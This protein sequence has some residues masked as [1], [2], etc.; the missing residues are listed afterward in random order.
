MSWERS[1]ST[2]GFKASKLSVV[3]SDHLRRSHAVLKRYHFETGWTCDSLSTLWGGSFWI[4]P[5]ARQ[6]YCKLYRLF[7]ELSIHE[8]SHRHLWHRRDGYHPSFYPY[9]GPQQPV[10]SQLIAFDLRIGLFD[11]FWESVIHARWW[12][13]NFSG[14]SLSRSFEV[15]NTWSCITYWWSTL[16]EVKGSSTPL[17]GL[18][19]KAEHMSYCFCNDQTSHE[20][21][22][23]WYDIR[24]GINLWEY[25]KVS[26]SGL[27]G[28]QDSMRP[29]ST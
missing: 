20:N 4:S 28:P 23:S 22:V 16:C 26:L 15:G 12:I 9:D 8:A 21:M 7:K 27:Y 29:Q 2:N 17:W 3:G 10:E 24:F 5:S 18:P 1:L 6:R 25:L 14:R 11:L 19:V 13:V